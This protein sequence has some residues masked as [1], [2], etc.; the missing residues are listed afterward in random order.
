MNNTLLN[1][2]DFTI[3]QYGRLDFT[4]FSKPYVEIDNYAGTTC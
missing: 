4:V 3:L 2:T 1:Y